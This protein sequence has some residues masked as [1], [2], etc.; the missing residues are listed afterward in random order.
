MHYACISW[1]SIPKRKIS[2]CYGL[3]KTKAWYNFIVQ[4]RRFK[5]KINLYVRING[6]HKFFSLKHLSYFGT[7]KK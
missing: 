2:S 3:Q 5:F 6:C 4:V 1:A 7:F